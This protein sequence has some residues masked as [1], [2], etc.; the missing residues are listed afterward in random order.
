MWWSG[1]LSATSEC[2]GRG[3]NRKPLA[4]CK[5]CRGTGKVL[6]LLLHKRYHSVQA[7]ALKIINS[8]E[9]KGAKI[10]MDDKKVYLYLGSARAILGPFN[11]EQRSEIQDGIKDRSFRN[12]AFYVPGG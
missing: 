8:P 7:V 6:Y 2:E 1:S 11:K 3:H 9:W 5:I 12:S 4:G 10:E